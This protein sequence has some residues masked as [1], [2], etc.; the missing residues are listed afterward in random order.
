M[1]INAYNSSYL[2]AYLINSLYGN[3][4]INKNSTSGA[5]GSLFGNVSGSDGLGSL[6]SLLSGREEQQGVS[7]GASYNYFMQ[8]YV[9]NM[10]SGA[11][12]L[13][14]AMN[15]LMTSNP[16]KTAFGKTSIQSSDA[17]AVSVAAS[18]GA[19]LKNDMSVFVEQVARGQQNQG[20]A[21]PANGKAGVS[22]YQQF[23]IKIG[24]QRHQV[25]FVATGVETN[26]Q[27]QNKMAAA[28][29]AKNLGITATVS[30]K[31]GE[32]TLTL[33]MKA[34]GVEK[35]A[36]LIRDVAGTSVAATKAD[37][38]MW[39][40]SDAQYRV[41]GGEIKTSASNQV[42]LGN[43]V[44]ATLKKATNRS[45]TISRQADTSEATGGIEAMVNA[46]NKLLSTIDDTSGASSSIGGAKLRKDL[47]SIATTYA[48]SLQG[49][50]IT[51]GSGG[52]LSVS[53]SK[54][55]AAVEDGSAQRLFSGQGSG[56]YGFANRLSKL[57]SDIN[58]S[59]MRYM[60]D[61]FPNIHYTMN[62]GTLL[63]MFL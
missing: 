39:A 58:R 9:V 44:T 35:G 60:N 4:S 53:E 3:N 29:N 13:K 12:A 32:S 42:D 14:T 21:L 10:K 37:D 5:S 17:D 8:N 18:S 16:S 34:E 1:A 26:E 41:D 59:P 48:S 7:L 62:A 43:G 23:E 61:V 22:G 31:N 51:V 57:A 25:S 45:V 30:T 40:A 47:T 50:G 33:D 56:N 27:L 52:Y 36:F 24:A 49:V 63:D 15:D 55:S 28:I 38:V 46:Y 2:G 19:A 54:L 11:S 20:A 6:A